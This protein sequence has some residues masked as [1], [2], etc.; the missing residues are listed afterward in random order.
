MAKTKRMTVEQGKRVGISDF[1]S[2]SVT[3]KGEK[4]TS[5]DVGWIA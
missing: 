5:L 1:P 3:I 2:F 4:P